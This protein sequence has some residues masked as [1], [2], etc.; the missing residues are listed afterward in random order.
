[1]LYFVKSPGINF[2]GGENK[3]TAS[4]PDWQIGSREKISSTK[5][6]K[7]SAVKINLE[8]VPEEPLW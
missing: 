1:M 8:K 4:L 2:H 3:E 7:S 6:L 5:N